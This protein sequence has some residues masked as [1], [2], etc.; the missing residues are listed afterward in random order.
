ME[1]K[2]DPRFEEKV[3]VRCGGTGKYTIRRN[4]YPNKYRE[5]IKRL[6]KKLGSYSAVGRAEGLHR[7]TVK[8]IIFR[9]HSNYT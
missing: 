3:C 1:R 8:N 9:N 6:Y 5:H 4:H 7:Q 2:V